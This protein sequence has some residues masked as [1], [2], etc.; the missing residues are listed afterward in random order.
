MKKTAIRSIPFAF[1]YEQRQMLINTGWQ[2]DAGREKAEQFI[3]ATQIIL[4]HWRTEAKEF[5]QSVAEERR[6]SA[7]QIQ[8][9]AQ[10]LCNDLIACPEDVLNTIDSRVKN[11]IRRPHIFPQ[12]QE[13]D[14]FLSN[15]AGKEA[16]NLYHMVNVLEQWLNLLSEAAEEVANIKSPP[17]K[18]KGKEK[19]LI[20]SLAYEYET[21]FKKKPSSGNG[22]CFINYCS[23]LSIILDCELGQKMIEKVLKQ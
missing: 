12:Y 4:S 17:S 1:T 22:S 11:K 2:T 19:W 5:P 21:H 3:N 9:S 16:P 7:S 6:Y 20:Y 13:A 18:N 8:K 23:A 15:V 14:Q 10:K